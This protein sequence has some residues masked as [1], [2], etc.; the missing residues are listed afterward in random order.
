MKVHIGKKIREVV[1]KSG[2]SVTEFARK[3]NYSRRNI[4]SIFDKESVDTAT[5]KKIG[6]VLGYDFFVDY[7]I[8]AK[9]QTNTQSQVADPRV[10]YGETKVQELMKEVEYLKEI[11]AL[12]KAQVEKLSGKKKKK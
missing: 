7:S 9:K 10:G 3:I 2:M 8:L 6:D 11:N 5:L 12:L 4:Y 1:N